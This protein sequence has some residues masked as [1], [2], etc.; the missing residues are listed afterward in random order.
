MGKFN[1]V[2]DSFE[3][4]W[5]GKKKPR[6]EDFLGQDHQGFYVNL[7]RELIRLDVE[8]RRRV[9]E[10]PSPDE[11]A[12]RFPDLEKQWLEY[13]CDADVTAGEKSTLPPRRETP[14]RREDAFPIPLPARYQVK[15]I[16]GEGGF[17][18]VY[19]AFDEQL[20]R[21]VAIK[22]PHR[23][24]VN[25]PEDAEAYM[26]EAR[27]V[28]SLDHPNIVPVH[29]VGSTKDCPFF[30]VSK[31]IEGNTLSAKMKEVQ[32]SVAQ[33]A[34]LV[35]TVA[36][37]LHYAHGQGLVHR[38]IKPGNILL[39]NAGKPYIVDFGLAVKEGDLGQSA[40]YAGTPA[41]MSPE[42]ARGEGHRV[43]GRSDIFS[44]GIV[45]YELLTGKRPFRGDSQAEVMDKITSMDVR[46]P[47]QWLDKIPKEL[48]RICL[49][50]LA[51]RASERY[52]TAKDFADDLRHFLAVDTGAGRHMSRDTWRPEDVTPNM[53]ALLPRPAGGAT[54]HTPTPSTPPDLQPIKILPKGLRSFDAHDA[55][56]FLELLPGPRDRD[57][58]PDSL[59]FWRTRIEET[60]P[61]NTF[62]VGL[63]YGPSGCG[64]S[65][66]IKAGLLPRLSPD[67]LVV[68]LEATAHDT[69]TRLLRGLRKR[70]SSLPADIL[71]KEALAALRLGQGLPAGKKVLIVL[72]QFEQ[73][74]HSLTSRA[75][76]APELGNTQLVQALRQCDGGRLQCLIMVRDDFWLAISRFMQEL[77]IRLLEGQNSALVD[78][79]DLEHARKVLAAFGRAFG[80]I[81][82]NPENSTK[83]SRE[84]LDQAIQELA[85]DGKVTC[86]RLALF[87]EMMKGKPWTPASLKAVGGSAGV[88]V[89][90]L[91]ETLSA[92]TAPPEHRYHQKA[93][94]A[95]LKALLPESGTDIKGHMLPH[96][97]L[98]NISGYGN[99]PNDFDDLMRILD[100]EIRLVTPTD[101]EGEREFSTREGKKD[102]I[103]IAPNA[104][105]SSLNLPAAM[106]RYYQLTHDYLVPSLRVWL[107]RKQRETRR[108]RAELLLEDCADV[109]NSRPENRQLPSLWQWF[110]IR[111]WTRKRNWT[112]AQKKM[113][114]RASRYHAGREAV[115]L[116]SIFLLI[117]GT[118]EG[119]RALIAH[120]LRDRLLNANTPDVPLIIAD[121][122]PYRSRVHNL[123][124]NVPMEGAGN[125]RQKLHI[126]LALARVD[127]TQVDYLYGRLLSADPLELPIIRDAL[128]PHKQELLDKLWQVAE[129][130]LAGKE[131]QR[132]RAACALAS[133]D[134]DSTR[135][136]QISSS[137]AGDL[138]SVSPV[139]LAKWMDHLFR[140]REKMVPP[141]ML[142]YG[143]RQRRETERL[144][145]TE[146]LAEY[147]NDNPKVL[148][149]LLMDGDAKQFARILPLLEG[150]GKEGVALL[151]T[152]VGKRI[153]APAPD[154][155]RDKQ[156]K[157][158]ANA[159]VA[160]LKLGRPEKAWPLLKHSSDPRVRS[161]LI[162]LVAPLGADP[163]SLSKRL[164][165]ETDVTVRRALI[166]SLGEYDEKQWPAAVRQ[167]M[168][169]KLQGIYRA[170][171]DPGL[172]AAAEWLVRIWRKEP[173]LKQMNDQW[174]NDAAGRA[175]I[176]AGVQ[177]EL[178]KTQGKVPAVN[179]Q[180][181]V[182]GQGQT[183]VIIPGRVEFVM[184][185]P[186]TEATRQENETQNKVQIN[187]TFA[188]AAKAV[189]VDQYRQFDNNLKL[190]A[191]LTR[192][193]DL[194]IVGTNWFKAAA[195]C[196]WLTK[197]EGMVDEQCCYQTD[198]K[199]NVTRLKAN[200]LSLS[201]YRLPTEAEMEYATR[202]G[203]TTSRFYGE[204][205]ELLS[206]YAWY[207]KNSNEQVWP[208]GRL[209]PNDLGLFDALGNVF[210]W[211]QESYKPYPSGQAGVVL[212]D[213]EDILNIGNANRV[214][215]GGSFHNLPS[216]LR[217]ANR[218]VLVPT[219][220]VDNVG[221]RVA[222]TITLD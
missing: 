146:I 147:A 217:S 44:L 55:D 215:R 155:L 123:L 182:N 32:L 210:T 219:N 186:E 208:V 63:L 185:S 93:A 42:Q 17:G 1:S 91:E 173:W 33:A 184:G 82:E 115:L 137:V 74:L 140:V 124:R 220:Q 108:G 49:K 52:T 101:P 148:A 200:Y 111:W 214:L 118:Y 130:P 72:D 166:L 7:V 35:A 98:L 103:S 51:K 170:E 62:S 10:A 181:Y 2:C 144:L 122:E 109:W 151:Q 90:F 69:E 73:W 3:A 175:K 221:F 78:L 202:A 165:E 88:G 216:L 133:F 164:V 178:R 212:E 107:T 138:V 87:A 189:T 54:P 143:D 168:L 47:R 39:D 43:D 192:A 57:G 80:R 38:D 65:S 15:K 66:L 106:T 197:E 96:A 26:A 127:P 76:E 6:I 158:Q 16:V 222:R 121:I 126:S 125:P 112:P 14:L 89:A 128:S 11:Y 86:V 8:Y 201:G 204:T 61:D 157:R 85:Q 177:Q 27:I 159:A 77:E 167:T 209:K 163:D 58:L 188:V 135:W 94:R 172:H 29:D 70:F 12:Q 218:Y 190:P 41:Y 97:D 75:G 105:S 68:Y 187:R 83:E 20:Q 34:D 67:V 100:R 25:R 154:E 116:G 207:L 195:Y 56:F 64:K 18:L 46:P 196:N 156:A 48:E 36:E 131:S 198:A 129:Q 149:D 213:K 71:V 114:Q 160:L 23:K 104:A 139:Q 152:E 9:G 161:Y 113:M 110:S 194:P 183:I 4:A 19:L 37:T 180:W 141:L 176:L 150:Q 206:K 191:K 169:E 31:F 145:A 84:F 95:I 211:C 60:D 119:F 174:L 193:G 179:P 21:H 81:P 28:A 199:G 40:K 99:R 142:V 22:V 59:R 50:A 92:V 30:I 203:A 117:W 136:Y 53:A 13:V 134:P 102:S 153:E 45:F 120:D 24:L 79:F 162:H 5:R 171:A 132:L 205:E